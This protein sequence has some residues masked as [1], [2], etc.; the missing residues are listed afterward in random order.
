M[1]LITQ[2]WCCTLHYSDGADHTYRS[3]CLSTVSGHGSVIEQSSTR[4]K[5]RVS[6]LT[7]TDDRSSRWRMKDGDGINSNH[8]DLLNFMQS[9]RFSLCRIL[10]LLHVG[11]STWPSS[12]LETIPRSAR[13]CARTYF[14]PSAKHSFTG[15]SMMLDF[16][17]VSVSLRVSLPTPM[18]RRVACEM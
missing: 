18:S 2:L 4:S 5:I 17:M 12:A 16:V 15:I 10:A 6:C 14:N 3:L 7:S 8:S 1:W 9:A 11:P 13:A